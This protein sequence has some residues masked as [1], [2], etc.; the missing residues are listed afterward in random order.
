MNPSSPQRRVL[1]RSAS[2]A[3][4][5]TPPRTYRRRARGR[6]RGSCDSDSD[7]DNAP[8]Q[9]H[10]PVSTDDESERPSGL[11]ERQSRK[12][13]RTTLAQENDD[14]EAFW[15]GGNDSKQGDVSGANT[16]SAA[17]KSQGPLLYRKLQAS[18]STS[19]VEQGLLSPPA[20]HRKPVNPPV[21]PRPTSPSP[22]TTVSEPVT[23]QPKAK[24]KPFVD[25]SPVVGIVDSP[26]NP[27]VATPVGEDDDVES[28]ASPKAEDHDDEPVYDK[29]T[30]TYV[31]RGVKRVYQNPMYDPVKKRAISPPPNSKLPVDDPLFS[32]DPTCKP[33]LLFPE[34]HKKRRAKHQKK[35][36]PQARSDSDEEGSDSDAD[37]GLGRGRIKAP[38]FGAGK[39]TAESRKAA[40][41]NEDDVF[42]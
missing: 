9:Q 25:D 23:P 35:P 40:A 6:S 24:S 32:P 7:D 20:S 33:R 31:F 28:V 3:S 19:Q 12:K 41:S 42:C 4:L 11:D 5:P 30:V 16:K 18:A 21:A 10:S 39:L 8:S 37:E 34:A 14:E 22:A 36:V 15:M 17:A 38:N 26:S 2:T 29:P 13:R 27:F 1:K